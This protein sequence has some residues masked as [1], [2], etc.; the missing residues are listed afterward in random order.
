MP[1]QIIYQRPLQARIKEFF[2]TNQLSQF[3]KQENL[4]AE[5]EHFRILSALGP[6][7]LTREQSRT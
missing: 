4:L 1:I 7:G 6:G 5:I 3:M 2:T